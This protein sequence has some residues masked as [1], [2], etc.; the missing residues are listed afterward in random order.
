MKILEAHSGL[1]CLL[2][3]KSD[4][5]GV[6]ISSLT[7]S[8]I[9]GLPDNELVP[10]K[11]RIELVEEFKRITDK[12]IIVDIDTGESIEHL[13][14]IIDWFQRAG[15]YAVIMEDKKYPKQNSPFSIDSESIKIL[16]TITDI[17]YLSQSVIRLFQDR[18]EM[19]KFICE[20]FY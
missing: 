7:H 1:S 19:N 3:D 14:F 20:I 10:L 8:A 4:F 2:I 9:K 18:S 15:A 13:P 11:E 17:S 16:N 12:P 5:D 6:W